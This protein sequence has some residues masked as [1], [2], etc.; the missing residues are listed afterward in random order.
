[1]ILSYCTIVSGSEPTTTSTDELTRETT[2]STPKT[3]PIPA[4]VAMYCNAIPIPA[5]SAQPMPIH[6]FGGILDF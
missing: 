5:P 1:M 6:S 3:S 2:V 4:P